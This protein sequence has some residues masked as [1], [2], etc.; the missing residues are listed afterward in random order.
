L[1]P[2]VG[3]GSGSVSSSGFSRCFFFPIF[4][5]GGSLLWTTVLELEGFGSLVKNNYVIIKY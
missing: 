2:L 3:F 5:T 4:T 1:L